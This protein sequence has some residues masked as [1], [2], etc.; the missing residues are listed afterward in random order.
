LFPR[1]A[2]GLHYHLVVASGL[3]GDPELE[4]QRAEIATAFREGWRPAGAGQ[5]RV[6]TERAYAQARAVLAHGGWTGLDRATLQAVR[7]GA[8]PGDPLPPWQPDPYIDNVTDAEVIITGSGPGQRVAV[9]FAHERFPGV[10]FGHRFPLDPYAEGREQI[11]LKEEIET[12]ALHRMMDSQ[13]TADE[14]GITWTTW[15]TQD[16]D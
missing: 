16:P 13:P 8:Q 3:D 15:R 9:L 10:R 4:R 6:L 5:P 12:G 1:S 2:Q 7:D 14:A 11:W